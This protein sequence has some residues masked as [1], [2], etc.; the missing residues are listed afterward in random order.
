LKTARPLTPTEFFRNIQQAGKTSLSL[1]FY[2]I[3]NSEAVIQNSPSAF[4]LNG[5]S[6][7]RMMLCR[8]LPAG[9]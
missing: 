2:P 5:S 8:H 7:T 3:M 9:A 4:G 6:P 1:A